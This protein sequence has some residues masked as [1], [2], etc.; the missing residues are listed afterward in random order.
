MTNEQLLEEIKR[1]K[2]LDYLF[3]LQFY[4]NPDKGT[5]DKK[6]AKEL[7]KHKRYLRLNEIPF[8]YRQLAYCYKG[9]YKTIFAQGNDNY[10][11][12]KGFKLMKKNIFKNL[13][14]L[15]IQINLI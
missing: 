8:D 13:T 7:E 2:L 5:V 1:D 6:C 11:L 3:E 15:K 10:S 14:K 12:N 9:T 4:S